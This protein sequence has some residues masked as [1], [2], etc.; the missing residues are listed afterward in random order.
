MKFYVAGEWQ[1]RNEKIEVRNPFDNSVID[2]VPKATAA[3]VE[4]ALAAAVDG[5]RT[6]A[7]TQG[8]DRFL[9]LRKAAALM[10][11]RAE[12]LAS[13]ISAE[14]GKTLRE[15][16]GEVDRSVQTLELSGE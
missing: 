1:D 12:E 16:R 6:M 15:S 14:E 13:T 2:T 7:A 8:Y 9:I 4:S 10:A 3:D 11:D 5:A